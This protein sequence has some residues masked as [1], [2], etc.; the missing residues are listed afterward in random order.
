M[1]HR[2][3]SG[4]LS[5]PSGLTLAKGIRTEFSSCVSATHWCSQDSVSDIS[6]FMWATSSPATKRRQGVHRNRAV[7][8][9]SMLQGMTTVGRQRNAVFAVFPSPT[10]L[11]G[12][13]CTLKKKTDSNLKAARGHNVLFLIYLPVLSYSLKRRTSMRRQRIMTVPA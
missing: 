4:V 1:P 6:I 13:R 5:A 8:E 3:T 11:R 2:A 7:V 9:K 12:R 10:W